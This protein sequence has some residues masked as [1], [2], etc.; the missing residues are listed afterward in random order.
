MYIRNFD[1]AKQEVINEFVNDIKRS[2]NLFQWVWAGWIPVCF[3][4]WALIAKCLSLYGIADQLDNLFYHFNWHQFARVE[5]YSFPFVGCVLI[6]Y[7][8]FLG[9]FE[10]GITKIKC[11]YCNN[12]YFKEFPNFLRKT[13]CSS[14]NERVNFYR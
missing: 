4:S 9:L 12:S 3:L 11:P 5:L 7:M 1:V 8:K 13:N 10:I 6:L 14:C 2:H